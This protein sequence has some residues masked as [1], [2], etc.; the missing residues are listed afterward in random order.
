M[1]KD[2]TFCPSLTPSYS[3]IPSLVCI[4]ECS[5][6]QCSEGHDKLS[7]FSSQTYWHFNCLQ[8]KTLSRALPMKVLLTAAVH[9]LTS[10]DFHL[11]IVSQDIPTDTSTVF[12]APK[13]SLTLQLQLLNFNCFHCWSVSNMFQLLSVR[14][15][16]N[17]GSAT[18]SVCL[19][20]Y[21][22]TT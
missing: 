11:L 16:S 7:L 20:S 21:S 8:C 5:V 6:S 10:S 22:L 12:R 3:F 4:A 9:Q 13:L 17:G 19:Q 18:L 14:N 15:S 2:W 1:S